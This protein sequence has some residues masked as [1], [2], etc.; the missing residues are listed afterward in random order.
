MH[1]STTPRPAGSPR[2]GVSRARRYVEARQAVSAQSAPRR[3]R[4]R[5]PGW[6]EPAAR[7]RGSGDVL[8]QPGPARHYF[9]SRLPANRRRRVWPRHG[10]TG[11]LGTLGSWSGGSCLLTCRWTYFFSFCLTIEYIEIFP[12]HPPNRPLRHIDL[13]FY[14]RAASRAIFHHHSPNT[15]RIRQ[16]F[17]PHHASN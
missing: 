5:R 17:S 12:Y 15:E 8:R 16:V 9:S 13:I 1:A 7:G 11:L 14:G 2:H 6:P 10:V 3:F 4:R